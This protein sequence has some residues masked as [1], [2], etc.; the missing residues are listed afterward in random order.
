MALHKL[1][2]LRK[3]VPDIS[4][5]HL[6]PPFFAHQCKSLC[7]AEVTPANLTLLLYMPRNRLGVQWEEA[8]DL[9]CG[10]LLQPTESCWPFSVCFVLMTLFLSKMVTEAD[11]SRISHS[12]IPLASLCV[13]KPLRQKDDLQVD[14]DISPK[15]GSFVCSGLSWGSLQTVLLGE[16]T[17][18]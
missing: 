4:F 18:D 13:S 16:G 2:F 6:S 12:L 3:G 17:N 9:S 7:G 14:K 8:C 5:Y 11:A 15:A 10:Q 1:T